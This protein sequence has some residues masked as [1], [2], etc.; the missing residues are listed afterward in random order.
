MKLEEEYLEPNLYQVLER[1]LLK[2]VRLWEPSVLPVAEQSTL[3]A[4]GVHIYTTDNSLKKKNLWGD[5]CQR[6]GHTWDTCWKI[7]WKPADFKSSKPAMD[8][9]SR[10]NHVSIEEEVM[11]PLFNPLLLTENNLNSPNDVLSN[12]LPKVVK[13]SI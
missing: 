6:S 4:H 7:H 10:G 2:R 9:D 11:L 3:A 1:S 8:K 12:F 13:I 5:H